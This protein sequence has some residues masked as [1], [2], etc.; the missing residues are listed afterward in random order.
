MGNNQPG[1]IRY[2]LE[3]K[4]IVWRNTS[5]CSR[6]GVSMKRV[7]MFVKD[8]VLFGTYPYGGIV[9]LDPATGL[10]L[11]VAIAAKDFA[12]ASFNAHNLR[13][14]AG[15]VGLLRLAEHLE[16]MEAAAK[17][18]R[19]SDLADLFDSFDALYRES[20]ALLSETWH[21]LRR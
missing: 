3:S 12:A 11:G 19:T 14:S 15:S 18:Q 17:A 5:A 20:T 8:G 6:P 7:H 13:N 4:K 16:G 21:A 10:E 2:N 1:V 9:A